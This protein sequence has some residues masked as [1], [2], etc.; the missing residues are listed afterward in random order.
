[1]PLFVLIAGFVMCEYQCFLLPLIVKRRT[2]IKNNTQHN[3]DENR[4]RHTPAYSVSNAV[5][6]K[7]KSG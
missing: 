6:L 7:I 1:M 3:K 2:T 5:L 4:Q